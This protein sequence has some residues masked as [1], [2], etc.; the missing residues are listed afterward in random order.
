MRERG[1]TACGGGR[2]AGDVAP[3]RAGGARPRAQTRRGATPRARSRPRP[4]GRMRATGG[5]SRP[6]APRAA[7]GAGD[8][9]RA[10]A[11]RRGVPGRRGR[12]RVSAGHHRAPRGGDRRRAPRPGPPQPV[13]LGR[14]R[15]GDVGDPPRAR[16]PPAAPGR[17]ARARPARAAARA[18]RHRHARRRCATGRCCCSGSPPRCDAQSSSRSTSR[19]SSST[20]PAG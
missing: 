17:A 14:G 1:R 9:A 11:T 2:G 5:C 19:I 12:P 18:D 6:G 3:D 15:R 7:A 20:P 8:P 10:P 4:G 13:R 16:H